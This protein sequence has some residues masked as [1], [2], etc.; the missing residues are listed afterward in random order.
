MAQY[1]YLIFDDESAMATATEEDW[2]M[3]LKA[4]ND[5]QQKVADLGGT[6]VHG[7]ALAPSST[8]TSV[9]GQLSGAPAVTDGPFA[10][11]K[12]ALGG[13][14]VIEAADLDQAI[15]FAKILPTNGGVEVRPVI[16]TSGG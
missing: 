3:M 4:H 12:E 7:D 1:M 11:T 6:I 14:Y 8:A 10:E 15:A 13:F 16:D 9:R 2:Q 5:F